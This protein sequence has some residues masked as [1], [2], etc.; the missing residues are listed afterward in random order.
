VTSACYAYIVVFTAV[1]V[2]ELGAPAFLED[3]RQGMVVVGSVLLF[4]RDASLTFRQ[5]SRLRRRQ[6]TDGRRR[7]TGDSG[8]EAL[9]HHC[10]LHHCLGVGAKRCRFERVWVVD[11]CGRAICGYESSA[12]GVRCMW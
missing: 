8:S 12:R 9:E 2:K 1:D 7:T 5:T 10:L 3:D 4:Q 11:N 6:G